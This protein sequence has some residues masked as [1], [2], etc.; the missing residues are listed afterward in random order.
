MLRCRRGVGATLL[1]WARAWEGAWFE[2]TT[3]AR[4]GRA[5]CV[6][7]VIVLVTVVSCCVASRS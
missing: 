5:D 1:R 2:V 3:G 7:P 6:V 4:E